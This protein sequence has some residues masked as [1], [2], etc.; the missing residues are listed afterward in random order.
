[1]RAPIIMYIRPCEQ[2]MEGYTFM[3][4]GNSI[5]SPIITNHALQWHVISATAT[6]DNYKLEMKIILTRALV[7]AIKRPFQKLEWKLKCAF[8]CWRKKSKEAKRKNIK[9]KKHFYGLI[10]IM[11][12]CFGIGIERL[13]RQRREIYDKKRKLKA[14]LVKWL[15]VDNFFPLLRFRPRKMQKRGAVKL[16]CWCLRL[17]GFSLRFIL[18]PRLYFS[19]TLDCYIFIALHEGKFSPTWYSSL[20]FYAFDG[21]K[22]GKVFWGELNWGCDEAQFF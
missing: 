7:A 20:G 4:T 15:C 11:L 1:M 22:W 6:V 5:F 21:E 17:I 8:G 13:E 2:L 18:M 19:L 9:F 12:M 10:L 14:K 16:Y 3:R